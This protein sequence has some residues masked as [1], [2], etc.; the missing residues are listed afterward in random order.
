[1]KHYLITSQF[2]KPFETFGDVVPQHRAHLQAWYDRRAILCSGP[3]ADRQGGVI[4]ARAG[5]PAAIAEMLAGDPYQ[6]LGLA[7]YTTVE[8]SPAK[9]QPLLEAWVQGA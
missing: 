2:L 7:R 1:M 6:R 5:D 9:H 8:F 4:L 3:R